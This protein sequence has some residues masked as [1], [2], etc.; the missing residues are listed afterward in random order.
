MMDVGKPSQVNR[1]TPGLDEESGESHKRNWEE[2]AVVLRKLT[3][4]CLEKLV[5]S[6]STDR[7][8]HLCPK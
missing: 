5:R 8:K 1:R 7:Y 3:Q 6:L 4:P 2:I